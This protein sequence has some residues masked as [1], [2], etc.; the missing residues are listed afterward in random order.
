M[1]PPI[2]D[3]KTLLRPVYCLIITHKLT[4]MNQKEKLKGKE[5]TKRKEASRWRAGPNKKSDTRTLE[6]SA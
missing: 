2:I 3:K 1:I 6:I 5:T 4:S